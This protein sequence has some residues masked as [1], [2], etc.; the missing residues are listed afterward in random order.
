MMSEISNGAGDRP[1]RLAALDSLGTDLSQWPDRKAANAMRAALLADPVLRREYDAAA[2]IAARLGGM[3]TRLDAA[4]AG[5]GSLDRI[6]AATSARLSRR[7]SQRLRWVAAAVIVIAAGLGS[8]ADLAGPA[9]QDDGSIEVVGLEAF[10]S[11]ADTD[12]R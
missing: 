1:E 6:A 4:I 12:L 9:S 2:A 10:F 3:R 7:P 11:P 5:G 8:V